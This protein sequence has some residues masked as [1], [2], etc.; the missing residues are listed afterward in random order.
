MYKSIVET[1]SYYMYTMSKSQKGAYVYSLPTQT[2]PKLI[3][4]RKPIHHPTLRRI[5]LLIPKFPQPR[6]LKQ[7]LWKE[8]F[9]NEIRLRTK[10]SKV[11][12]VDVKHIGAAE[13]AILLCCE[14][15]EEGCGCEVASIW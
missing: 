6:K 3:R 9:S 4:P 1:I 13:H 8:E 12:I 15:E 5:P 2:F 11:L 14:V 7:L 10:C